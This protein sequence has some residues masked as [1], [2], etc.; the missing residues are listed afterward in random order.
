MSS[1]LPSSRSVAIPISMSK[2]APQSTLM[3]FSE[4]CA[5]AFFICALVNPGPCKTTGIPMFFFSFVPLFVLG[6][7]DYWYTRTHML[8]VNSLCNAMLGFLFSIQ[9]CNLILH[10]GRI[11]QHYNNGTPFYLFGSALSSLV[12]TV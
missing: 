1:F 3:Y 7:A 4:L 6:Y 12:I 11:L 5:V 8:A 10:R 9:C 2:F